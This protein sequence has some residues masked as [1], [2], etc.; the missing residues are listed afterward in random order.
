MSVMLFFNFNSFS[1]S[2]TTHPCP[3]LLAKN[4][5]AALDSNLKQEALFLG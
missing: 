4:G 2:E 3:M 1:V 5:L